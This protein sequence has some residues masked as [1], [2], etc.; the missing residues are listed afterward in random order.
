[1]MAVMD[2]HSDNPATF[3]YMLILDR[4]WNKGNLDAFGEQRRWSSALEILLSG[5]PRNIFFVQSGWQVPL[6]LR[7]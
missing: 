7:N 2:G 3:P 5:A 6:F 4:L 1:M